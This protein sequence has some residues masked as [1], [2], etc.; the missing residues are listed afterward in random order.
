MKRQRD[1]LVCCSVGFFPPNDS[2]VWTSRYYV[3]ILCL[4]VFCLMLSFLRFHQDV[5]VVR[6]IHSI[7]ILPR[8]RSWKLTRTPYSDN[9]L[10][11]DQRTK[12]GM[13][14]C[15]FFQKWRFVSDDVR[16][17]SVETRFCAG[18]DYNL[19]VDF[20]DKFLGILIVLSFGEFYEVD[21]R[22]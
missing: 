20:I 9:D 18:K 13:V 15:V 19:V 5:V 2:I 17:A 21:L 10:L 8:T 11:T 4:G 3:P 12:E 1:S 6:A 16:C 7:L 14:L 22:Y